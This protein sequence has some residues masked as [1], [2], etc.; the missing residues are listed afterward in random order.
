MG[1]DRNNMFKTISHECD[2]QVLEISLLN[3][4]LKEAVATSDP[5][6][7]FGPTNK[8][9]YKF[10][11]DNQG[12]DVKNALLYHVVPQYL[13]TK[14]LVPNGLYQTLQGQNV[15]SN[16]YSCPT[17]NNVTTINGVPLCY[18]DIKASNGVL[19]KIDQVLVPPAGN[20]PKIVTD[21]PDFSILLA[22]VAKAGLVEALAGPNL[23]VFAPTNQAFE[24]L[25]AGLGLSL[26]QILEL[27]T[28]GNILLYHVLGDVVF[29]AA[30][31]E[32]KTKGVV[33]LDAGE[34]FDLKRRC[35][36]I[37]IKDYQ[38][39]HSRV[40]GADVLASNGVIHVIDKVLL[41]KNYLLQ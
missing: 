16:V 41:P 33:T 14:D 39:R 20:I 9:L 1:C 36:R 25:S 27:P 6:T 34:T 15:R 7:V 19:H 17:F 8:A 5:I 21:N 11:S 12:A 40:I 23:T 3:Q 13:R 30:I 31:K 38:C 2:L 18:K 28:L 22:A 4:G 29:S 24:D 26:E 32:G 10:L 35:D 37:M